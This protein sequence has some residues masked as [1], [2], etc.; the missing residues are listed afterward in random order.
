MDSTENGAK[1]D[2][3]FASAPIG[4]GELSIREHILM[5]NDLPRG[6][7]YRDAMKAKIRRGDLVLEVG[8]GA[9][10]L[11]CIAARLGAKHVYS[12]EQSPLLYRV[13][14]T[15]VE[16]NGLSDKITLLNVH[17][18]DLV[19]FGG[20]PGTDRRV[21][22]GDHRNSGHR[23]GDPAHPRSRQAA[24][25]AQ[26]EN[27]PRKYRVQALPRQHERHPRAGRSSLP[28][29]GVRPQRAQQGGGHQPTVLDAAHRALARSLHHRQHSDLRL[30]GFSG[31]RTVRKSRKSSA[32]MSAT[33]C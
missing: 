1:P 10:L 14:R 4:T 24:A 22:D 32:K 7:K 11:S 25:V 21:R 29:P 33:A 18:K 16:A 8:T 28:H 23:R 15:V 27:H 30:D 3:S 5:V 26:G 17:S 13:A 2:N 12:I 19:S 6:Q 31:H 9:G 20:D